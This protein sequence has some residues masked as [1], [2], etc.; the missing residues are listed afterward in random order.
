[1]RKNEKREK[2][3]AREYERE[4]PLVFIQEQQGTRGAARRVYESARA[5][6]RDKRSSRGPRSDVTPGDEPFKEV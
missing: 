1:M 6:A 2:R 3:N 4:S 5:Y